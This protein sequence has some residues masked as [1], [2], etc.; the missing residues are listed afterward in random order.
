M[1]QQIFVCLFVDVF[2]RGMV[3]AGCFNVL[4]CNKKRKKEKLITKSVKTVILDNV[5]KIIVWHA[6]LVAAVLAITVNTNDSTEGKLISLDNIQTR[7]TSNV[8]IPPV[9]H[10]RNMQPIYISTTK[11]SGTQNGARST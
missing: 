7:C 4:T 6:A 2:V 3:G 5:H 10:L 9:H 11:K 1:R 8:N